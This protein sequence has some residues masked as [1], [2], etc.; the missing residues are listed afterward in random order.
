[1]SFPR[2]IFS[3]L[4]AVFLLVGLLPFL[5]MAW[6]TYDQA[7]THMTDAV[8]E[9]WLVRLARENAAHV[10][11][12]LFGL[13]MAVQLWSEEEVLAQE[14]AHAETPGPDSRGARDRLSAALGRRSARLNHVALA[15]IVG[16]DGTIHAASSS[17]RPRA[18]ATLVG[19]SIRDLAPEDSQRAW[20]ERALA[21]RTEPLQRLN[22]GRSPFVATLGTLPGV[23]ESYQIGYAAPLAADAAIAVLFQF[24]VIQNI[25]DQVQR[26]FADEPGGGSGRAVR[27]PTGYAFLFDDDADTVIGHKDR[28]L[29][30]SSVS[31]DHGLPQ[32]REAALANDFGF[33]HYEFR[34]KKKISG[35]AHTGGARQGGFAW[36]VGVGIDKEDIYADVD[37]LGELLF[38]ATLI[39]AGLVVLMAALISARITRPLTKLVGFTQSVARGNLDARVSIRSNDEIAVLANAFNRMTGDLKETNQRLIQAEKDAAW[40]EMARQVAHEIKNPLTPIMLSAQ[41]IERA[42]ADKHPEIDTIVKDSVQ[43]IVEQCDS[44]RQI[45]QNFAS[46]AAFPKPMLERVALGDL[47]EK[48]VGVYSAHQREGFRV[49]S[50]VAAKGDWAVRADVDAMRRVFLN[51]F[52]NAFEAM[53]GQGTITVLAT[54]EKSETGATARIAVIDTGRGIPPDDLPH[55]FEPYFSTRTGGT[56]LGLAICRKIVTEHDGTISVESTVG[57]GTTFT[58]SLPCIAADTPLSSADSSFS[59]TRTLPRSG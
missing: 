35:F 48:V 31:K 23:P 15:M 41:Q 10:D 27:Y 50:R 5:G 4:V 52:N 49:V 54:V 24:D 56:G 26:K 44:L 55:L 42:I 17:D 2:G 32:L 14:A 34:G 33:M 47:V 45:A 36:T 3:K 29:Y 18:A 57:K 46:Y 58:I 28:E 38:I 13:G 16:R 37:A 22:W 9:S 12:R 53:N 25:L 21:I 39:V 20:I 30:G 19:K 51:L 8:V 43:S 40:R 59:E 11:R 1:L 6:W 7:K